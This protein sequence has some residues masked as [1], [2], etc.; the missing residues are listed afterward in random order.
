MGKGIFARAKAGL[1]LTPGERAALKAREGIVI[2]AALAGLTAVVPY[3]TSGT[4]N[5]QTVA[6]VFAVAAVP[7][8]A[9]AL[10]KYWTAQGDTALPEPAAPVAPPAVDPSA[11]AQAGA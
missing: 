10:N 2:A 9:Y 8:F 3:L 7:A 5:W 1:N 6:K 4:V 11:P